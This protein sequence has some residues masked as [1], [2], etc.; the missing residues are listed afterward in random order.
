M[1]ARMPPPAPLPRGARAEVQDWNRNTMSRQAR[2]NSTPTGC[3]LIKPTV[4]AASFSVV[5][6]VFLAAAAPYLAASFARLRYC[7]FNLRLYRKRFQAF[8]A[9][10]GC[11]WAALWRW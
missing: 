4:R 6:A 9:S 1:V 10:S 8:I 7:C 11:S 2:A 5:T 3:R